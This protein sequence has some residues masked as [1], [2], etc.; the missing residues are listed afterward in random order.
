MAFFCFQS[1]RVEIF[2][3]EAMQRLNLDIDWKATGVSV[4][5]L[6]YTKAGRKYLHFNFCLILAKA[7]EMFAHLSFACSPTQT[8]EVTAQKCLQEKWICR[9]C[10]IVCKKEIELKR[11]LF[12][13]E[14]WYFTNHPKDQIYRMSSADQFE[15]FSLFEEN[16]EKFWNL[17]F[18]KTEKIFS[19]SKFQMQ[20]QC[21][22]YSTPLNSGKSFFCC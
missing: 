4:F 2:S 16:A 20:I 14:N 18:S 7:L 6:I 12:A 22:N 17:N 9:D 3:P 15:R 1:Q 5:K 11:N 19:C 8:V 10:L 21:L 13:S